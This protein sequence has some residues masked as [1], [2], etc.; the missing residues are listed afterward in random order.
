MTRLRHTDLER[1]HMAFL[2]RLPCVVTGKTYPIE[3]AH[4]RYP[5]A[6]FKKAITGNSTKPDPWWCLPLTKEMHELQHKMGERP[7]WKSF[8]FDPDDVALSPLALCL[9]IWRC[10][11]ADDAE[12]AKDAIAQHRMNAR[13]SSEEDVVIER[14][15]PA[16]PPAIDRPAGGKKRRGP[17][18]PSRPFS[19]GAQYRGV[20]GKIKERTAK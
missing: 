17:K 12:A 5:D 20:N 13:L 10:S 14:A 11:E 7:F 16:A 6:E 3:A 9:D 15:A 18:I 19:K 8:L 4:V 1:K 2:H